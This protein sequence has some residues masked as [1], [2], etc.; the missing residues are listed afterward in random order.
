MAD[1][2][3]QEPKKKHFCEYG[4]VEGKLILCTQDV[5]LSGMNPDYHT[6]AHDAYIITPYWCRNKCKWWAENKPPEDA[7]A[8]KQKK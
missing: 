1:M 2:G 3:I 8:E 4:R 6:V 5:E 7:E